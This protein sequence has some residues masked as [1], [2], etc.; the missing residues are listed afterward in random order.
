LDDFQQEALGH[1]EQLHSIV[2]TAPTGAGRILFSILSYVLGFS[3]FFFLVSRNISL[4]IA[5]SPFI[6]FI[7]LFFFVYLR[8]GLTH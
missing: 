2:V 5:R 7:V 1:I 3:F 8:I 6:R 4:V